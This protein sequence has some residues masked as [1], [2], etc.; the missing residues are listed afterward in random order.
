MNTCVQYNQCNTNLYCIVV[1][2]SHCVLHRRLAIKLIIA[3]HRWY[4]Q[5]PG[6]SRTSHRTFFVTFWKKNHL[7][8]TCCLLSVTW[9]LWTDSAMQKH[10]NTERFRRS[11]APYSIQSYKLPT[12][13]ISCLILLLI[14]CMHILFFSHYFFTIVYNPAIATMPNKSFYLILC[15]FRPCEESSPGDGRWAYEGRRRR[16]DLRK[17]L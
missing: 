8:T 3:H 7:C 10:L 15:D 12:N 14:Y 4:W 6:L 17:L 2:S 16:Q 13:V 5:P 11:F 9:T 1:T